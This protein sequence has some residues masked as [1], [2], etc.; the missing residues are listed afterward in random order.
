MLTNISYDFLEKSKIYGG[1]VLINKIG[2]PGRVYVMPNL[3]K[4][5]SLGMNLFM[6]RLNKKENISEKFLWAYLNTNFGQKIIKKEG[7]WNCSSGN[8][9]IKWLLNL[10]MFQ[11]FQKHLLKKLTI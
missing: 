9:L 8:N 1:E 10:C 2:S 6:L 7:K 5:V 4:P 11:Y 3:N